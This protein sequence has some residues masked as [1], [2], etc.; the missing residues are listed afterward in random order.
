MQGRRDDDDSGTAGRFRA[1]AL[2]H[3]D[4]VYTLA[5]HLLRDAA[6]ADDAT[7]DCFLRALRH[8]ETFRGD[9]I[10]PWLFAIL[11][12]VCR[13]ARQPSREVGVADEPTDDA[14]PLWSD[15]RE[16]PEGEML[17]RRDADAVRALVDALPLAFREVIVLRE[18]NDLSYREI[19]EIV[20]V[21]V[22]TVMSRLARGRALLRTA[23]LGAD[24]KEQTP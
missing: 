18:I 3:L 2:P 7:Q 6:D 9:D 11:R 1:L 13:G 20:G 15:A 14:A 8:F 16:T 4:E 23:W 17:R 24:Q 21:P 12:N 10:R 19:A 22:G 5:R